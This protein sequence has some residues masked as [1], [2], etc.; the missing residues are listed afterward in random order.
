MALMMN[1]EIVTDPLDRDDFW[2]DFRA[3]IALLTSLGHSQV[4][5]FFGF[6]WGKHF[7]GGQWYDMPMS[8][9]DLEQRIVSAEEKGLGSFGQDNLYF[10]VEPLSMRLTYSYEGTIHLSYAEENDVV[11]HIRQR[12]LSQQWLTEMQKSKNYNR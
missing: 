8:L 9:M 6:S 10:T 12:W 3:N 11:D 2:A 7:Y 5:A 4:L 1:R